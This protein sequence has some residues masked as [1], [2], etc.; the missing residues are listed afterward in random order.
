MGRCTIQRHGAGNPASASRLF[1][2]AQTL[3]GAVNAGMADGHVELVKLEALWQCT[4]HLN[5][6]APAGRPR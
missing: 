2:T 5:W 4:W 1:D 6:V 3:P